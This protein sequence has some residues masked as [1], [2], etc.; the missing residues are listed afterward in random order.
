MLRTRTKA[1]FYLFIAIAVSAIV[2]SGWNY[3]NVRRAAVLEDSYA[4]KIRQGIVRDEQEKIPQSEAA[5]D[6]CVQEGNQPA[7]GFNFR[8]IC[9]NRSA[10][11][12]V[13]DWD[14]P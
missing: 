5:H 7:P 8:V 9:L 12:W 4:E 3:L 2:L 11:V 13:L 6:R 14:K 10:V 1:Y